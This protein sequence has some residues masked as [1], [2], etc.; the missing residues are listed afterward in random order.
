LFTWPL[1]CALFLVVLAAVGARYG[2]HRDE[3]YF[4][5]AGRHPAWGYAD[6]PPLI[7]LAAAGWHALVS[8]SLWAFR[9]VPAL[10]GAVVVALAALTARELGGDHRDAAWSAAVVATSTTLLVTAH[11]FGTTV[12]D[13]AASAGLLLLLLRSLRTGSAIGWLSLGGLA[14]VALNIKLLPAVLLVCCAAAL[15]AVG[16][17][18][19]L[20]RPW[21]WLSAAVALAGVSGTLLWQQANGWPQLSLASSVASGGSGSSVDRWLFI[22]ML[23]TL[24]GPPAVA[25]LGVGVGALWRHGQYRWVPVAAGLHLAVTLASGGKPYYLMP[26]VPVLVAAAVPALRR[27]AQRGRQRG[28]A[29]VLLV[30]LALNGVSGVLIG[31][32]VLPARLAPV[33]LVYDLGEQVGWRD[34][35][36][37]VAAADADQRADL[38]LTMNYG[39]AGALDLARRRG[40]A[41]PPVYSGHNAYGWWGPPPES[42]HR[43]LVVGWWDDATLGRWFAGCREI[44]R[45]RNDQGVDNEEN[46][47]PIRRCSGPRETWQATWPQLRHL[48]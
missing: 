9:L 21:P 35:V 19:P 11:L 28:R 22:P 8:G 12:F 39:E 10:A 3:L 43:V 5:E 31:L 17:R 7:P 44:T 20:R 26:W 16:P 33:A 36:A 41:T 30:L 18:A 27:W 48:N 46:G 38:V 45:V 4:L 34:L 1:V 29:A 24:T 15:L 32:P 42:A 47:A 14:A 6:Q 2:Y 37:A 25:V 40:A 23:V 13:I